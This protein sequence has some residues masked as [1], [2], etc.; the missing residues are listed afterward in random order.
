MAW[1]PRLHQGRPHRDFLYQRN[2]KPY[3][4]VYQE[5]RSRSSQQLSMAIRSHTLQQISVIVLICLRAQSS[6][7][8]RGSVERIVYYFISYHSVL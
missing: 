1:H 2:Q 5:P 4:Y 8:A 3:R 7:L 6:C